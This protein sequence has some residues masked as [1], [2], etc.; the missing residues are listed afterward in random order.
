[1]P[2]CEIEEYARIR[3]TFRC[4]SAARLPIASE[5]VAMT[6]KA[7]PQRC[8]LAGNAVVI[9]RNARSS[10]ATLVADDIHAVTV[11][12]APSYTSGV[13]M[14][15]GAADI[16]KPRP[17]TMRARPS[18]RKVSPVRPF[19]ATAAAMPWNEI[20]PVAP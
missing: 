20:V 18:T 15:N 3:F 13:H 14:W 17:A 9:S 16:L 8:W 1:K 19:A 6:A 10:A 7:Q 12:G 2:A 11:V 4:T 5:I